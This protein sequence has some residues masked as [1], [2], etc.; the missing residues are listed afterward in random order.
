M[1]SDHRFCVNATAF[2]CEA[3]AMAPAMHLVLFR[4]QQQ[5]RCPFLAPNVSI[6]KRFSP[7]IQRP[8]LCSQFVAGAKHASW[9]RRSLG[10][11]AAVVAHQ[12]TP[13]AVVERHHHSATPAAAVFGKVL[14]VGD[15]ESC[16]TLN[17]PET[18]EEK[19]DGLSLPPDS[20]TMESKQFLLSLLE[21]FLESKQGVFGP[22]GRF[23]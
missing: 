11:A 7:S 1:R 13:A 22:F 6:A 5:L 20:A 19:K 4:L 23:V 3:R 17:K 15:D 21:D 9:R 12:Q 18:E 16:C 8:N 2:V 10:A 14:R